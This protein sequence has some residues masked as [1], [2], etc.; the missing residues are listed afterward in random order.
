MKGDIEIM[1]M[2]IRL[3]DAVREIDRKKEGQE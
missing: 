2:T 3:D 1:S